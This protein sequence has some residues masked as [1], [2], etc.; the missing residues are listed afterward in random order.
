MKLTPG[1]WSCPKAIKRFCSLAA[2]EAGV[3]FRGVG[4][5]RVTKST[6]FEHSTK[7]GTRSLARQAAPSVIDF[8]LE[9]LYS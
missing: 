2:R 4:L 1:A 6:H 5:E 9:V 7:I 8:R 3:S